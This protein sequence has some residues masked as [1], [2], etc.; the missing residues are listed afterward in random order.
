M[1]QRQQVTSNQDPVIKT[2]VITHST[3][4]SDETRPLCNETYKVADDEPRNIQIASIGVDM[5]I[6]KVGIDQ[7]N[8]IAVPDNIHVA[9]WF[10]DSPY[11]VVRGVSIIDGHV[12][13]RY[14]DAIFVNL[15]KV[16]SGEVIRVEL[17]DGS[18]KIFEAVD[19]TSYTVDKVMD[20]CLSQSKA[21]RV[22]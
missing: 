8:A 15:A 12:P 20:I 19:N 17:G 11:L 16:K 14:N 1:W 3:D 18:W 4:T 22:N 21:Q 13:G 2:E 10:V 9:G 6:Q 5:C 7:H